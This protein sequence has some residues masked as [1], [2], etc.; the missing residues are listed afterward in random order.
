MQ[1]T[2]ETVKS[3]GSCNFCSRGELC[4]HPPRIVLPY[5]KV[6]VLRDE[7]RS[8]LEARMCEECRIK[9][10]KVRM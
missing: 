2:K 3:A 4:G 9:L 5:T 6:W 8:G 1:I 7:E 10:T